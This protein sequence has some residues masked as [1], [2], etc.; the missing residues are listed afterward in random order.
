MSVKVMGRVWDLKLTPAKQMVLLALADHAA[1]DGSS[2]KPGV[3]LIA[4]KTGYS[5]RQVQRIMRDLE[6]DEILVKVQ[7]VRG[8]PTVYRIDLTK[9]EAKEPFKP[10]SEYQ[11][12]DK[13]SDSEGDYTQGDILS[14]VTS[15][16]K[17]NAGGGDIASANL[18]SIRHLEPSLKDAAPENGAVPELKVLKADK[19]KT[20][21][22][23]DPIF[24]AVTL[25]IFGIQDSNAEGGR[26]AKISNWL[27]GKYAGKG[28]EKVGKI[29]N[30]VEVHH[31]QQFAEYCKQRGINPPLDFVKFVE[32][33]R[34]W[35]S[36]LKQR[37]QVPA[38]QPASTQA[39]QSKPELSAAERNAM[40]AEMRQRRSSL[41]QNMSV[42]A[43]LEEAG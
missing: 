11:T 33:W 35:A 24:D 19:P 20:E 21:R 22:Q 29:S 38:W 15:Q 8:R 12:P 34:K 39:E 9:G 42:N 43:E 25:H 1:H 36:A 16:G 4:W 14:G 13:M 6:K 37:T 3:P 10:R 2:V 26:I 32:N 31:V 27:S 5:E 7:E 18:T 23:P 41:V 40:L 28:I 17:G 30:P